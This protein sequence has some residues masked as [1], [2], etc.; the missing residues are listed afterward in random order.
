MTKQE[1]QVYLFRLAIEHAAESTVTFSAEAQ[2]LLRNFINDGVN[3]MPD[4][5]QSNLDLAE[6]NLIRIIDLI[7]AEAQRRNRTYGADSQIILEQR[8]F[9]EIQGRLNRFW[10]FS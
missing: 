8:T 7:V 4:A 6:S 3:K 9:S 2:A 10:P 5:K 1:F